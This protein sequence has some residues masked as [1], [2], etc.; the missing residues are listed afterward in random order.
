MAYAISIKFYDQFANNS[1]KILMDKI[2]VVIAPYGFTMV[3]PHLYIGCDNLMT[4]YQTI[5][6]LQDIF[7]D[8][9][10]ESIKVFKIDGEI[11]DFTQFIKDSNRKK[12]QVFIPVP[13]P[14][15]KIIVHD[16]RTG[17]DRYNHPIDT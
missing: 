6:S 14:E 1:I 16:F 12:K 3:Q 5:D 7:M 13:S 10:F 4:L 2:S 8:E 15:Q 17:E 11:N 9:E